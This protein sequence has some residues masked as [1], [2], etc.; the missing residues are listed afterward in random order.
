MTKGAS[1][2]P[3]Q[4]ETVLKQRTISPAFHDLSDLLEISP[5]GSIFKGG[6]KLSLG[7][8]VNQLVIHGV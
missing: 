1:V 7:F 3:L 4:G 5:P 6:P 2:F 8:Y